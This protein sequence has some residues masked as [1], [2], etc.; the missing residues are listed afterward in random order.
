MGFLENKRR[1]R[2]FYRFLSK[3]YDTV[4]PVFWN[5]AMRDAAIDLLE[6]EGDEKVLDVGCGTGFATKALV[7]NADEVVALDQ[8]PHQ[9]AKALKK[10]ELGEVEFVKGDAENL[11]FADGEFDVVWSSGSIEYWPN[12]VATLDDMRRVTKPGGKVLVVGPKRPENRVLAKMADA[13]MLF[14]GD[15]EARRMFGEAGWRDVRNFLMG[16]SYVDEDAIVTI[17][18][19]P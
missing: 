17:A 14:Y 2:S 1:A 8:S 18:K 3:V 6:L 19:N 13:V 9:L 7:D 11:P 16:S 4:N 15:E 5:T 10:P 12:P